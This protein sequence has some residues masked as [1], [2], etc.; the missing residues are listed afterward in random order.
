[1]KE[2]LLMSIMNGLREPSLGGVHGHM[3]VQAQY[4]KGTRRG[5]IYDR[6]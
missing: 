1:M 5:F 2:D 4:V 6:N 3:I